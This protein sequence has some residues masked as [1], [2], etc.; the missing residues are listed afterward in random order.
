MVLC[1][2]GIFC[3]RTPLMPHKDPLYPVLGTKGT[4]LMGLFFIFLWKLLSRQIGVAY[5]TATGT[6]LATVVGLNLYTKVCREGTGWGSCPHPL[7]HTNASLSPAASAPLAGPMGPLR[8][9]GCCQ[10]CQYPHDATTVSV[11][12][13]QGAQGTWLPPKASWW[14]PGSGARWLL[15]QFPIL[16][17]GGG[18]RMRGR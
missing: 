15:C 6:A 4:G 17:A 11:S 3:V 5:V 12:C 2:M 14:Q 13:G 7:S 1:G 8:S 10:L 16:G 9:R 18:G